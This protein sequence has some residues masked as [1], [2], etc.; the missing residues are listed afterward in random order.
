MMKVMDWR[1]VLAVLALGLAE[2]A[3]TTMSRVEMGPEGA[4][5]AA[6][7][8]GDRISVV[9]ARGE[10]VELDV[11]AVGAGYIEGSAGEDELRLIRSE[12]IRE[13]RERRP[14]PAKTALLGAGVALALFLEALSEIEFSWW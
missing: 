4:I 8:P 12:E 5:P 9:D 11:T 2:S 3:C 14:A 1:A 13:L 7:G 6:I 10:L